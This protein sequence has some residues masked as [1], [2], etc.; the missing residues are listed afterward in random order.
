MSDQMYY[1]MLGGVA[2]FCLPAAVAVA[3]FSLVAMSFVLVATIGTGL[4][5]KLAHDIL[6]RE[7][8]A[9]VET[10]G[11]TA[12]KQFPKGAVVIDDEIHL[13]ITD[14]CLR[15]GKV[16]VTAEAKSPKDGELCL[17]GT[18]STVFLGEDGSEITRVMT[19]YD[20]ARAFG[21]GTLTLVQPIEFWSR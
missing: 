5:L 4:V 6:Q 18:Q 13:L 15:E 3:Q 17:G 8:G 14:L 11:S 10:T 1:R 12:R 7:A 16:V 21:G 19:D 20:P 9:D 2:L